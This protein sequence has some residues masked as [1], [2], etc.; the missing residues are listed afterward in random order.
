MIGSVWKEKVKGVLLEAVMII[1]IIL[2]TIFFVSLFLDKDES[3]QP[4]SCSC[5]CSVKES[6]CPSNLAITQYMLSMC[7]NNTPVKQEE[8][9]H[10]EDQRFC[11]EEKGLAYYHFKMEDCFGIGETSNALK[12]CQAKYGNNI[13]CWEDLKKDKNGYAKLMCLK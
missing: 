5:N 6:E 9:I 1:S 12:C 10:K 2:V 4:V 7:I 3:P 11:I 13:K 8:P